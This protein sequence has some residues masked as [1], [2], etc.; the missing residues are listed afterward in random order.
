MTSSEQPEQPRVRRPRRA[1][2]RA[3]TVGGDDANLLSTLPAPAPVPVPAPVAVPA[4]AVPGEPAIAVRS[5]DDSDTGWGERATD[6]N[7]DRLSQDK[8]PHW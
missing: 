1:V 3:G 8:P 7:D 4:P 6:S 2:R 5:A